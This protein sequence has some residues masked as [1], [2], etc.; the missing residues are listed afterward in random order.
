M[1]QSLIILKKTNDLDKLEKI[2]YGMAL[3]HY[4][5]EFDSNLG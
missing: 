3:A 2:Y 4:K 5:T 1:P